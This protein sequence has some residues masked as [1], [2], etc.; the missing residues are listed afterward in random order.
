[1]RLNEIADMNSLWLDL[2]PKL[3]KKRTVKIRHYEWGG[4]WLPATIT[5]VERISDG[6][7]VFYQ[8]DDAGTG[9]GFGGGDDDGTFITAD[10][11]DDWHLHNEDDQL[12]LLEK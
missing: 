1:M 4:K 7:H 9:A 10:E 8:L 3:V 11:V 5:D 6:V 2:L 12:W